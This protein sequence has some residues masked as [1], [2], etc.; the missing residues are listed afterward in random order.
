VR[1][2]ARSLQLAFV[3]IILMV[4]MAIMLL[5]PAAPTISV[6]EGRA[7]AKLPPRPQRLDDWLKLPQRTSAYLEDHFG[8]RDWLTGFHAKVLHLW[9]GFG[10]D[11]VLIGHDGRM[12]LRNETAIE[13]S[14]GTIL[15]QDRIGAAVAVVMRVGDLLRHRNIPFTFAIAP[16]AATIEQADLPSWAQNLGRPTEY[17]ALLQQLQSANIHVIDLRPDLRTALQF[18]SLYYRHGSHWNAAGELVGFN[19]IATSTGHSDWRVDAAAAISKPQLVIGGDLARMLGINGEVS[20]KEPLPALPAAP[21]VSLSPSR[22]TALQI[23]TDKP[24]LSMLVL[25][26]SFT[27]GFFSQLLAQHA[28]SVV[29]IHEQGCGFDWNWIEHI[30]PDEVW[31]IPTERYALCRLYP[32][33]LPAQNAGQRALI[34][35]A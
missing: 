1:T 33:N 32:A 9:L 6:N 31:W 16:N 23:T 21:V 13:Q 27:E 29:W 19:T 28:R 11:R 22:D 2:V 35:P 17:D 8:L 5:S 26:D 3:A 30:R 10:S 18:G 15:R 25:G 20:S 14:A 24:G 12:Y 34:D 7:L 4:P